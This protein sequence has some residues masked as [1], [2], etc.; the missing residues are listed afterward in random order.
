M[1]LQSQL[2]NNYV[3]VSVLRSKFK[4]SQKHENS[5]S[6]KY[7]LITFLLSNWIVYVSQLNL[8]NWASRTDVVIQLFYNYVSIVMLCSKL[9]SSKKNKNSS[10]LIYPLI[11]NKICCLILHS[12][13]VWWLGTEQDN[14]ILHSGAAWEQLRYTFL[15]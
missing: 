9:K 8:K 11:V 3:S 10:S 13:A 15:N 6:L 12:G 1:Q 14:V 7:P 2:F 4:L 5:R